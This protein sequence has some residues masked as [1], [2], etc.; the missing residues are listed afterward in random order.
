MEAFAADKFD[1][2]LMDIQMPVLDGIAACQELRAIEAREARPRTPILA[3]TAN[4]MPH[5]IQ[6]Y[7]DAGMDGHV[8]KPFRAETLI[9][10]LADAL[11]G[12]GG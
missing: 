12:E 5:Q 2:I 7:L 10:S 4:A 6:S 3:L 9:K 1:L 11:N 8:A